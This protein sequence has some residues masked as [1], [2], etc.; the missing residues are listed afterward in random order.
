MTALTRSPDA[1][2]GIAV[3]RMSESG[4]ETANGETSR[5]YDET[6]PGRVT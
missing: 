3:A 4:R 1:P 5:N 6:Q 2:S